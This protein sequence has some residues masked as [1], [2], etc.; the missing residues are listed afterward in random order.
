MAVKFLFANCRKR[1]RTRRNWSDLAFAREPNDP[2]GDQLSQPGGGQGGGQGGGGT[3]SS[4]T[5]VSGQ[6][7]NDEGMAFSVK[8]AQGM[9]SASDA[10][11]HGTLATLNGRLGPTFRPDRKANLRGSVF[12]KEIRSFLPPPQLEQKNTHSGLLR[13]IDRRV[14][15]KGTNPKALIQ[16]PVS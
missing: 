7:S 8:V 16:F 14:Q 13:C 15:R 2:G 4:S 1:K 3:D 10:S 12:R 5:G 6:S 9:V 11:F